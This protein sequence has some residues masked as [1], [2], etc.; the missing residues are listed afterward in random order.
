[1]YQTPVLLAVQLYEN[2]NS[3]YGKNLK[4]SVWVLLEN[5]F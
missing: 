2:G 5:G 3:W 1:M 4:D